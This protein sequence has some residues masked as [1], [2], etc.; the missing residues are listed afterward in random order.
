MTEVAL[1]LLT[2]DGTSIGMLRCAT[3]LGHKSTD[4]AEGVDALTGGQSARIREAHSYRFEVEP[5]DEDMTIAQI[6]PSELFERDKAHLGRLRPGEAVGRVP[7]AVRL[8]DGRVGHAVLDV[9]AS[10]LEHETEYRQMLRDI[11]D[12]AVDALLQG[13]APSTTA[14]QSDGGTSATLLFQRFAVLHHSLRDPTLQSAVQLVL[15]S[16]HNAWTVTSEEL[17]PGY[18]IPANPRTARRLVRD[19]PR[20]PWPESPLS[21][22]SSLPRQVFVDRY[23]PSVDTPPNRA[24]KW[25]LAGWRDLAASVLEVNQRGNTEPSRRGAGEARWAIDLL[26]EWLAAPM[27]REISQLTAFPTSNQ[28]LLRREGY[29]EVLRAWSLTGS[30]LDLAVDL[31]EALH[32]SQRSVAML[33]EYWVY[34]QL[35]DAMGTIGGKSKMAELFEVVN[36]GMALVLKT[37]VHH[38]LQWKMSID[39]RDLEIGLHFNRHFGRKPD[40]GSWAA[41]MRPDVSLRVGPATGALDVDAAALAVWVHFD[42]KYRK[43]VKVVPIDDEVQEL[44]VTAELEQL[45]VSK[46]EDVLK[47]HAYRDAIRQTAGAY[48]VFPGDSEQQ[49]SVWDELLPGVGALPLRPSADGQAAFGARAMRAFLHTLLDHVANQ[50]TRHERLRFWSEQIRTGAHVEDRPDEPSLFLDDPP[51]DTPVLIAQDHTEEEV[52]ALM[53]EERYLLPPGVRSRSSQD[54]EFVIVPSRRPGMTLLVRRTGGWQPDTT[55]RLSCPVGPVP[56]APEWVALLP[57]AT[58]RAEAG[59]PEGDVVATTWVA[60]IAQATKLRG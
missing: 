6:Q 26:D 10:K 25:I 2:D 8:G 24:I 32:A 58:T 1:A 14:F 42:A 27:F 19:R 37:G 51:A 30:G 7:V 3:L 56:D 16:P 33:Y 28:V 31:D 52:E 49:L 44:E 55:G 54:V 43:D 21:A 17:P 41:A 34:L 45:G 15:R 40:P 38:E 5:A 13:F 9:R 59:H 11:A 57:L 60:L 50:A 47:M 46:R 29:R 39:G 22:L 23:E 12:L 35:A 20:R 53:Q 4:L 48:V 18:P 36:G